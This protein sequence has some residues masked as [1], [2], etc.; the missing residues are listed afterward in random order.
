M[1]IFISRP[2]A[3]RRSLPVRHCGFMLGDDDLA[4]LTCVKRCGGVPAF[5]EIAGFMRVKA[6]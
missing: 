4:A 6:Q 2:D 3:Y 5:L 1:R